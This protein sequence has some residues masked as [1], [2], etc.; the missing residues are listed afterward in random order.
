MHG[1]IKTA[2]ARQDVTVADLSAAGCKIESLYLKLDV[3]DEIFLR[4]EGLEGRTCTVMWSTERAAG[5]RFDQPFHPAVLDNLC[6]MHGDGSGPA[7][8]NGG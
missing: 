5:V 6:R 3:G 7:S 1:A 2:R 8:G 4:P